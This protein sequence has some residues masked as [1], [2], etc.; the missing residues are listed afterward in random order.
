MTTEELLS[1]RRNPPS[2]DGNAEGNE[3]ETFRKSILRAAVTKIMRKCDS[4]GG[5]VKISPPPTTRQS[6]STR[7]PPHQLIATCKDLN[8]SF[9]SLLIACLLSVVEPVKVC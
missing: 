3:Y 8:I 6:T 9:P 1:L 5:F 2:T 4:Q 7:A